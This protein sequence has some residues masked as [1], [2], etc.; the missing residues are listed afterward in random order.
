MS[1]VLL[2]V[3]TVIYFLAASWLFCY[4]MNCYYLIY[5][6]LRL[7]RREAEERRQ[8]LEQ[9]WASHSDADLP[10]VTTQL[11]IYNERYVVGRLID[12]VAS[13]DY[14][15][16]KHQIQVLD[17]SNDETA[18]IIA[19]RVQTYR[20]QGY[21]IQHV[22]RPTRE[23][24]KAGALK[25]ATFLAR[26]EFIAVF[27]ADFVPSRDFLRRTVPV[28]F[29]G[30][31]IAMVQ[32]RW[33]YM[34]REQSLLTR[35]QALGTDGHFIIEQGARTW[36]GLFMNFNGTA[37]VWRKAAI[38]DAGGWETDT[39]TEDLDLSYR[40]QLRGW[41]MKYLWEVV[42][43]SEL[44]VDVRA[45]KSQ[46]HRWAKGS[47]QTAIKIFP[48][49]L[50]APVSPLKKFEAF[51]HL[52][53]YAIHPLMVSMALLSL[54]VLYFFHDYRLTNLSMAVFGTLVF[55]SA[56]APSSMFLVGQIA[57]SKEWYRRLAYLP[58][59]MSVG[60]GVAVNNA[61]G[62]LEAVLGISSAFVRT[63]KYGE[64]GTKAERRKT[65]FISGNNLALIEILMGLYCLVTL[66][67]TLEY[68]KY[69]VSFF[70]VIFTMG[71]FTV[72]MESWL[73]DLS[74]RGGWRA[75]LRSGHA[76]PHVRPS[77]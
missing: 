76:G 48:R 27:D 10:K 34:N 56:I 16:D 7:R 67:Q 46:Q 36:S 9:F 26:G 11:P 21:D 63:P 32:A 18:A 39:L 74:Q 35:A 61:R 42:V 2:T 41:R 19:E 24:Y 3:A 62:V 12:S 30:E 31:D 45:Y 1:I 17:D 49:V 52:T 57:D 69:F 66:T 68:H 5:L 14:P 58:V 55:F 13:L 40:V 4:G 50:R 38:E 53:Q 54:P 25:H 75:L 71:F 33:G 51:I 43:P 6:F 72:G 60:M 20:A 64:A 73:E 37:G 47:I 23:G 44:P 65:Y 15:K 59:L 70:M 28:F 8:H 22:R 29:M 77:G